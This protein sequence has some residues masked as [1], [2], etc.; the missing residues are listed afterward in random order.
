ME[1]LTKESYYE[2]VK[3]LEGDHWTK[4]SI[5][6]RWDYH[7]KVQDIIKELNISD[8]QE[9]LEMGTMGVQLVIDS[10]T[11]DY[12]KRWDFDGKS[13][14]IV[15]DG[16]ETPWPMY[17][18]QYKLFVAMRVFMHLTPVQD[19]CFEEAL[20]IARH[21]II[22][23]PEKYK[24]SVLPDS[25]GI[26]YDDFVRFGEGIHPNKYLITKMGSLFYWDTD[27]PAYR[28]SAKRFLNICIHK[29][30]NIGSYIKKTIR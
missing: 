12:E 8:P 11:L 27:A 22:V 18:K 21:V 24:N 7:A 28:K 30:K 6:R 17:D 5:D 14:T 13:P 26:S 2:I 4:G 3:N 15:H 10:H 23:V 29:L 16:R 1:Y 9:I 25:K 19:K 20:R